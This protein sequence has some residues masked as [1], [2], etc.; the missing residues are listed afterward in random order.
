MPAITATITDVNSK[1]MNHRYQL[2]SID[3]NKE[4]NKIP[5][6][7]LKFIDGNIA[8]KEFQILDDPFFDIG[9]ELRIAVKHEGKQDNNIFS[10]V[11]INKVVTLNSGG[12]ILTVELSDVAIRMHASRENEVYLNTT[13]STI[14]KRLLQKNQ[15][16]KSRIEDTQVTHVQMIQH[17]TTDWDFLLSRAEANA[18]VV[19]V[20]NGSIA[21]FQPKILKSSK[22]IELGS[23]EIYDLDLQIS[24][25]QQYTKVEAVGWDMSKQDVTKPQISLKN[26]FFEHKSVIN[27]DKDALGITEKKLMYSGHI[28]PDELKKW[29][30]AQEFKNKFSLIQGWLKVPGTTTYAVGD[31]LEIKEVGKAFSGLSIISG[32]RHGVTIEGWS[33]YIQIGSNSCWFTDQTQV[34]APIAGG[35][36]PGVN[37]LQVGVIKTTKEDPNNLFRVAVYIPAFGT[38]QNTIW[39]RLATLDAGSKR[40][41]FSIPEIGDEVLVG[42]LN[43]DPRQAVVIGSLYS[44]VN[45]PP[46]DFKNHKS[47]KAIISTAGYK[48]LLDEFE[49]QITIATSA[50]NSIVINEKEGAIAVSDTNGNRVEMNSKGVAISSTKDCTIFCD[51][52]FSLDASGTVNIKGSSVELL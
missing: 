12:S 6:A 23:N 5:T 37:G 31:T 4:F 40:G 44:P 30:E 21:V 14:F 3:V 50:N 46:L 45:I 33:T 42:F 9:K 39:A 29:S 20:E 36:L 10:G 32:I 1:V 8:K 38:E 25:E 34:T 51:G 35:L 11:I 22:H 26:N 15:L 27:I 16:K 52:N 19:Q 28:Q 24:G 43:D 2:L 7:E 17:Y 13:D 41:T 47:S 48:F 49:E 18:K